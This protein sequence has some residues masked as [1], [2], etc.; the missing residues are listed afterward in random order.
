MHCFQFHLGIT[1]VPRE[2]EDNGYAIFVLQE[3]WGGGG[4]GKQGALWS[5]RKR[6]APQISKHHEAKCAARYSKLETFAITAR[7]LSINPLERMWLG[8]FGNRKWRG[9]DL[10]EPENGG[11]EDLY[12]CYNSAEWL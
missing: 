8:F 11:V 9:M 4:G 10:D 12:I 3:G 1:V 6:W 2:I 7:V 5:M